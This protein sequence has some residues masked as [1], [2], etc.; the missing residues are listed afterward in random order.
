MMYGKMQALFDL[1]GRFSHPLLVIGGHALSAH[2][3]VRQ[4]VDVDCLIA[5]ENR[6]AF[7]V[8]LRA[9]GFE[10]QGET[11]NFARYSH[12][13]DIMPDVDVLFVDASTFDKLHA[14]GIL[15][16]RGPIKLQAPTLPHLIALKLHAIRNNPAR[17]AGD[18]GDI[19]RLLQAN[20][21]VV[22]ASELSALCTQ[23]GAPGIEAKLQALHSAP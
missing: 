11:E 14:G 15:L 10:R 3:V 16:Q 20:P 13:S 1:L 21:G 17:E 4:T 2:G 12:P 9:G 7:D 8:H 6:Q 18:L 23:F 19:A 22:S 5:V